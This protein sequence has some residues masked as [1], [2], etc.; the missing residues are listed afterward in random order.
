MLFTSKA[1]VTHRTTVTQVQAAVQSGAAFT[2]GAP[3]KDFHCSIVSAATYA[4]GTPAPA[5]AAS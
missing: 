1:A 2:F 5:V 3:S 4:R